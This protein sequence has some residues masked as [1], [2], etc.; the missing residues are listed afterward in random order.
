MFCA[1]GIPFSEYPVLLSPGR[2]KKIMV[3]L[4][5]CMFLEGFGS[6]HHYSLSLPNGNTGS[7]GGNATASEGAPDVSVGLQI[8]YTDVTPPERL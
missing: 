7:Q 1:Q 6:E 2:G 5:H 4:D 8:P 3:A